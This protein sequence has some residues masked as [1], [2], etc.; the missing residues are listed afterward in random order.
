MQ[1]LFITFALWQPLHAL[2]LGHKTEVTKSH[3]N[4][5][6]RGFAA[7]ET[8]LKRPSRPISWWKLPNT[9]NGETNALMGPQVHSFDDSASVSANDGTGPLTSHFVCPLSRYQS[10]GFLDR[11][12][13]GEHARCLSGLCQCNLGWKPVGSTSMA[14]GWSGLEA[15]TVWVDAYT[16]GCTGRCYSLACLEVPQVR[17]CFDGSMIY[18]DKDKDK[19]KGEGKGQADQEGLATDDLHLGAIKAPVADAGIGG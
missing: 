10:N 14:R 15:L 7:E 9:N 6:V 5:A 16:A 2:H 1:F 13:C 3:M 18:S 17:G 12:H 19:D 8:D 4:E 11:F